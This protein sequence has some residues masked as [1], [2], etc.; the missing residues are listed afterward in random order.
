MDSFWLRER[1]IS[2]CIRCLDIERYN[3]E[4]EMSYH[5]SNSDI[6]DMYNAG[7]LQRPG[8]TTHTPEQVDLIENNTVCP[9]CGGKIKVIK[10]NTENGIKCTMCKHL[11][12]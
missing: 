7:I 6:E 1:S 4:K 12:D 3:K 10:W 8:D 2:P 5:Y 9:K 11:F